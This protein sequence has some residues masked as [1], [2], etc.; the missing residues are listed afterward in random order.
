[1]TCS[2]VASIMSRN[3]TSY[4]ASNAW[5]SLV[6]VVNP[7]PSSR[8][9]MKT[10]GRTQWSAAVSKTRIFA[11]SSSNFI[12][13]LLH[14]KC[15][16]RVFTLAGGDAEHFVE[17]FGAGRA[18]ELLLRAED[19]DV[20][21]FRLPLAPRVAADGGAGAD[22]EEVQDRAEPGGLGELHVTR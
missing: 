13:P 11:S 20:R 15:S 5:R 1:M 2:T 16:R 12:A 7:R 9:T 8:A 22:V 14:D 17:A 4:G 6:S 19:R 18:L 21:H 10:P 3:R